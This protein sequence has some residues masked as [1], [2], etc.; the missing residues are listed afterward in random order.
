MQVRNEEN[1]SICPCCES[2]LSDRHPIVGADRWQGVP[3][4]FEVHICSGCGAGVT[5]PQVPTVALAE[6]YPEAY[7]PFVPVRGLTGYIST[8]LQRRSLK[9]APLKAIAALP[10]G[11]MVDVGCGRGDL[12]AMMVQQGWQVTGVEPSAN[13]CDVARSR[14]VE[15]REGTLDTVTLEPSS[16][17]AAVFQHSLEH[18]TDPIAS[19]GQVRDALLP[20]G[21][22]AIIVPNF[23]SWQRKRFGT[24]WFHLDLPRHRLHFTPDALAAAFERAGLESVSMGTTSSAVGLPGTCQYAIFGRCLFRRGLPLKIATGLTY[25]V[26]PLTA[27]IDR[28]A[29]GGDFLWAVARRR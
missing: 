19:L 14:G 1:H 15:A 28:I 21:I 16:N 10:A 20:G 22:V 27:L 18:V 8:A 2:V 5:M 29:G 25:L 17:D 9:T 4:R 13:A 6:F 24:C 23:D 26:L 11:R 3:G 12:G 7:S